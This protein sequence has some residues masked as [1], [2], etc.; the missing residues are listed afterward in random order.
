MIVD[1]ILANQGGPGRLTVLGC[2]AGAEAVVSW[3]QLHREAQ[4]LATVLAEDGIGRGSRVGLLGDPATG[5]VAALQAVWLTGAA[6][7]VLPLPSRPGAAHQLGH[8]ATDAGLDLVIVDGKLAATATTGLAVPQIALS[9]LERRASCASPL[10]VRL[11]DPTDL[12]ILQYTS[13]STRSPRGVPVTHAHLAA[14]LAA[15]RDVFQPER[16]H[17]LPMVSWLPLYHDMGLIGFLACAM[18]CGC[19][20]VLQSPTA[21]ALRPASWLEALS[22]HRA[23]A[24]GAPDSAYRLVT[25]LLEAGMDID[26]RAVRFML[27]GGEPVSTATMRRFIAA[28]ARYGLDPAAIVPAYGLAESTLVVTCSRPGGGLT[29]DP[30]DPEVL[31]RDGLAAPPRREGRVRMLARLGRPV[32]GT[33]LRIVDPRTGAPVPERKLGEVQIQGASVVGH[34]WGEP[35]PPAGSWLRTGDLGYLAGGDLVLCGRAKDVL[36]AAGRNLYP[37]DIELV[38]GQVSGVRPGGAVAFGRPGEHGDRLVIIVESRSPDRSA[39]ARAVALAVT[40]EVG[41]RPAHVIVVPPGRLPRTTSGKL[42]RAEARRRYEL[43]EFPE[44]R[45]TLLK[46]RLDDQP[47]DRSGAVPLRT[48]RSVPAGARGTA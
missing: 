2:R 43:G 28:A 40:A 9:E 39:V 21:F 41:M 3:A 42:R 4:R 26:L 18:S 31:E 15:L 35:P 47:R 29:T 22:R 30:V 6:V 25:P 10:V 37:S 16:L 27:S 24:T 36:F 46:G 20:L 23:V 13:G 48:R 11:P 44:P 38:A 12:A 45:Q 33:R 5:L 17:P 7:T 8:I 1:D 19:P 14:N 34:Y 32:R